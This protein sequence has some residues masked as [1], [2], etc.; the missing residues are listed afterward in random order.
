M[1]VN[2]P[3]SIIM[4]TILGVIIILGGYAKQDVAH[5]NYI[6]PYRVQAGNNSRRIWRRNALQY[7]RSFLT[8]CPKL[9]YNVHKHILYHWKPDIPVT[10][11]YTIHKHHIIVIMYY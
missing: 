8:T 3:H 11:Y 7:S 5:R 10:H 9:K 4:I 6:L 1:V 2:H